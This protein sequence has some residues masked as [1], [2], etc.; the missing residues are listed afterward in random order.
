MVLTHRLLSICFIVYAAVFS[1]D[2]RGMQQ[3]T[4]RTPSPV[5]LIPAEGSGAMLM[6]APAG[7]QIQVAE[8]VDKDYPAELAKWRKRDCYA[9]TALT[10]VMV[11]TTV[12]FCTYIYEQLTD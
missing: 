3:V 5:Q 8:G 10:C 2:L 6:P 7:V 1:C 12:R 4:Q 11:I 9:M